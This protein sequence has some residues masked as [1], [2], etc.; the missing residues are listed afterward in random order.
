[1]QWGHTRRNPWGGAMLEIGRGK[2]RSC[3]GI[4]RRSLLSVGTLGWL[5]LSLPEAL[6]APAASPT[7]PGTRQD[8]SC[9]FIFLN[10]GPSQFETFDPKPDQ[11]AEVRGPYGAIETNV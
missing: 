7:P 3:A 10:G 8:P 2:A 9:I 1:M 6:A 11:P 5:G 4:S